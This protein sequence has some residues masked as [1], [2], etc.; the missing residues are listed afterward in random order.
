MKLRNYAVCKAH[1]HAVYRTIVLLDEWSV[2]NTTKNTEAHK[3]L[4][5]VDSECPYN[6]YNHFEMKLEYNTNMLA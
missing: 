1:R 4:N 3:S 6:I 2:K 5:K